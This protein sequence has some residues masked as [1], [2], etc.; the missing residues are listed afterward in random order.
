[1]LSLLFDPANFLHPAYTV[2]L[3]IVVSIAIAR[4]LFHKN[5]L[6]KA[7]GRINNLPAPAKQLVGAL[8]SALPGT[9]VLP[10]DAPAFKQARG[11]YWNQ[12]EYERIPSSIVRPATVEQLKV[13]ITVLKR[14]YDERMDTTA[15]Q[16]GND[17]LF[18]V[19]SGG[20][21]PVSGAASISGGVLIDLSLFNQLKLSDDNCSIDIG[22][23]CRWGDVSKLLDPK[24]LA[25]VGGRNSH[26]GVG[27]LLLGGGISFY[28]PRFG[29]ACNNVISYQVVLAD[30]TVVEA[31]AS[32]H[33]DLWRALKG[34]SNNFGIVTRFT[35]RCFPTTKIWSGFLYLPSFQ[36]KKVLAAVHEFVARDPYDENAA[37]PMACFTY[38]QSLGFQ[39]ISVNLVYTKLTGSE[40]GWPACFQSSRFK[41]LFR[42]W[43][44]F[45]PR[46]LTNATDELEGLNTTNGREAYSTTTIKNDPASIAE[47]H[48]AYLEGMGLVRH[49]KGIYWTLVLQPL[50]PAWIRKGDPN[51]MGLQDSPD[52]PLILVSYTVSWARAQDDELVEGNIRKGIERI[53]A[54]AAA[55]NTGHPYRFQNY[56][57]E[58]Q[59]PFE[60]YGEEGLRF[61]REM[62]GK[63]DPDGLF[64]KGCV[65]GFKLEGKER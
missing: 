3:V 30:G 51:P 16:S 65:G 40:K 5:K 21:S 46:T 10:D 32:S 17:G 20:H 62:S 29:F 52:M 38:A 35:V 18:A 61:L 34:G 43:S 24:G 39:A 53:D 50:L 27:G 23:G 42:I 45:K 26:V 14:A 64:Q 12:Q 63:Y 54:F 6:N 58:W 4:A 55:R 49:V 9:V 57:G 36:A 22:S 8:S 37:G 41:S 7:P 19:R 25:V 31:S 1:M 15:T 2:V 48:A 13:A 60:G 44:T 33:P 56:C 47:A 59:N 28:S 11:Y